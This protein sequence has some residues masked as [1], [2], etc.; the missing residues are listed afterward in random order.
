MT[1]GWPGGPGQAI[2]AA[3]NVGLRRTLCT[4]LQINRVAL[5]SASWPL[6]RKRQSEFYM[7][8]DGMG[9]SSCTLH[10]DAITHLAPIPRHAARLNDLTP[11]L[12]CVTCCPSTT[13]CSLEVVFV[14]DWEVGFEDAGGGGRKGMLGSEFDH[15]Q[16]PRALQTPTPHC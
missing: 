14:V 3:I 2:A 6:Y 15:Q 7:V 8:N 11:I 9:I 1:L 16:S 10:K 5:A 13:P 12:R 4:A